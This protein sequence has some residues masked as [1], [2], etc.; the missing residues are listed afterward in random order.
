MVQSPLLPSPF[1]FDFSCLLSTRAKVQATR[2]MLHRTNEV[3]GQT[4]QESG[5]SASA[6]GCHVRHRKQGQFFKLFASFSITRNSTFHANFFSNRS[7]TTDTELY[8]FLSHFCE[9]QFQ[10]SELNFSI[11]CY[12]PNFAETRFLESSLSPRRKVFHVFFA[13]RNFF[14]FF[15]MPFAGQI[16]RDILKSRRNTELECAFKNRE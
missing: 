10:R 16:S 4:T 14:I 2:C 11:F 3:P 15:S 13:Y 5:T 7:L 1:D 6:Q 8:R 12:G 9:F